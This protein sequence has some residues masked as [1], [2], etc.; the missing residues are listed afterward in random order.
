MTLRQFLPALLPLVG[1]LSAQAQTTPP[2]SGKITYEVTR[3]TDPSQMQININGQNVRPGSTLPDGRTVPELPE[4]V[5]F[6]QTLSFANGMA[7]EQQERGNGGGGMMI[8]VEGGPGGDRPGGDRPG[9]SFG[10]G[11]GG[12]RPGGN[13][14]GMNRQFRRPFEMATYVDGVNRRLTKVMTVRKDSLTTD[15]YRTESPMAAQPD[16][17]K[18]NDKTK[19]IAGF[20]CRKATC[21]LKDVPYTIWYTTELPFT[22]SPQPELTPTKG[23]VLQIESDDSSYKATQFDTKPVAE[24]DITP[25][26]GAKVVTEAELEAIR[27]KAAADFRQR[28]MQQ[29]QPRN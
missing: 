17:W 2:A 25:P 10:N 29:F 28:M 15:V 7:R 19:K 18:D 8:R 21:T 14:Q 4:V 13:R 6:G 20:T 11:P 12:D 5:T 3:H 16:G 26:A 24:A 1:L 22:Y 27:K 9:G 23:V